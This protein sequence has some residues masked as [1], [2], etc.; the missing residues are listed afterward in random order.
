MK[1]RPIRDGQDARFCDLVHLV[2]RFYNTLKDTG[3][4]SDMDN[5]HMLSIIKQKMCLDDRE[6]WSRDREKTNQ[7]AT[8]LGL[9]TWMTAEMRSRMRATAP[10][11]T[12]SN[13]HTI[14]HVHVTAGSRNENKGGSHRCW[15]CKTHA[16]W[17][18]QYQKFLAFNSEERHEHRA[19]KQRLFH[20]SKKSCERPQ[21]NFLQSKET[22]EGDRERYTLQTVPP[23]SLA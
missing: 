9:M 11:R 16:H 2:K 15:I 5:S 22:M 23:S 13:N 12:R 6:V 21:V 3:L 17:T 20:V 18:D 7:P 14:H 10:H 4:P 19:R 8:L 1:F